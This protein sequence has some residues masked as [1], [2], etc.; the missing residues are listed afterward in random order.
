MILTPATSQ[1]G[2]AVIF[3]LDE[4]LIDRRPAWR[5]TIE[6]AVAA[7]TGRRVHAGALVEAYHRRPWADALRVVLDDPATVVRCIA[8]CERMYARS[9][10][11]RLLVHDGVGMALDVLREG[12]IDIGAISRAP[13]DVARK[14][15][16]STG[17]DRFLAVLAA[18]PGGTRWSPAE[19]YEECRRYL[20]HEARAC[21]FVGADPIDLADVSRSGAMTCRAGW[22]AGAE[23]DGPEGLRHPRELAEVFWPG[24]RASV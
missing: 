11:K 3:D 22:A 6:E 20:R 1:V 12:R 18:T 23:G 2:K 24:G 14:Q 7:V 19:R 5:Y 15:V 9:S 13:E 4:T 10:M 17:L 21:L 8:M 16:E